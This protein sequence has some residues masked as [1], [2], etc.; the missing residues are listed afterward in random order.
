MIDLNLQMFA[1]DGEP[2]AFVS[3]D[4][5]EDTGTATIDSEMFAEMYENGADHSDILEEPD[6]TSETQENQ[7]HYGGDTL[8]EEEPAPEQDF[9]NDRNA[10]FASQRRQQEEAQRQQRALDDLVSEMF[11]GQVNPFTN[12]PVRTLADY[13]AYKQQLQ[14]DQLKQ[15]GISNEQ[16]DQ[17]V[18]SRPEVQQA[19]QILEQQRIQQQQESLARGQKQLNDEVA[20]IAKLD[21]SIKTFEDI[22]ALPNFGDINERVQKG[23]T[24]LDAYKVVNMDR[25]MSNQKRAI[26]Q[27][28]LNQV[29]SKSHMTTT[30]QNG[31]GYDVS[32]PPEIMAAYREMMPKAT[33]KEIQA[34][35]KRHM[36][37]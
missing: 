20:T 3:E 11:E 29:A 27:Q 15:A 22:M 35:Y 26:K 24:L 28:T 8:S 4:I 23:Y 34:H 6:E 18:N 12:Q 32:V 37:G 14:E 10:F 13:K 36:K 9:K 1:E 21:P 7:Q 17:I 5:Q 16:L 2:D 33:T 30:G 19:Q 25:I 31:A